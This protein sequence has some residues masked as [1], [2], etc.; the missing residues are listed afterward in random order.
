MDNQ[1]PKKD[2][3]LRGET[4][5]GALWWSLYC[6]WGFPGRG[7]GKGSR[8]S[9]ARSMIKEIELMVETKAWS[10]VFFRELES[11]LARGRSSVLFGETFVEQDNYL[12]LS[13]VSLPASKKMDTHI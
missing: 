4:S 5:E 10:P 13:T 12:L 3:D 7:A 8:W 2:C 9:P 1:H 6:L 11:P